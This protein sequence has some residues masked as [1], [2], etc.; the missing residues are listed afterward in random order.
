MLSFVNPF[1][2]L[3]VENPSYA[4]KLQKPLKVTFFYI[5]IFDKKY[6]N[7]TQGV[8][9]EDFQILQEAMK[10]FEP[11]IRGEVD[12]FDDGMQ[13]LLKLMSREI[14]KQK[15]RLGGDFAVAHAVV[16]R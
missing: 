8:T 15:K 4:Q 2:P 6:I 7:I 14:I 5:Q 12:C 11:M 1:V 10:T 13:P 16:S 9:R 3:D